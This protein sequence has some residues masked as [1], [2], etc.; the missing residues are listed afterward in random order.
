MMYSIELIRS[1]YLHV[2][3]FLSGT[4]WNGLM[5]IVDG[6]LFT[7]DYA[8]KKSD[9]VTKG[10]ILIENPQEQTSCQPKRIM[11]MTKEGG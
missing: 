8:K 7:S 3:T 10:E 11:V 2:P 1:N 9:I 4:S 6:C 5:N